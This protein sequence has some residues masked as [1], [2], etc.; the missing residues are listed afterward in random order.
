MNMLFIVMVVLLISDLFCYWCS[1]AI[2]GPRGTWM[3]PMS[4]HYEMY[5]IARAAW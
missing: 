4:G 5:K 3:I 1:V 2:A